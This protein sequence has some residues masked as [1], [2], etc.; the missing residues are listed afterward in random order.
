LCLCE[1]FPTFHWDIVTGTSTGSLI[2]PFVAIARQKPSV[3]ETLAEVY[4]KIKKKNVVD[5]N[6]E[7]FEFFGSLI[8][9]RLLRNICR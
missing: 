2:A 7:R 6:F 5:S 8:K 3:R 9:E 4:K 1:E